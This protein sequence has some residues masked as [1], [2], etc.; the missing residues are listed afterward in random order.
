[1][2]NSNIIFL[3]F[4]CLAISF[5]SCQPEQN[6][7][8]QTIQLR[9]DTDPLVLEFRKVSYDHM[10]AMG[11]MTVDTLRQLQKKTLSCGLEYNK[12]TKAD[13]EECLKDH[14]YKDNYVTARM[15]A[16]TLNGLR[17]KI[18]DNYPEIQSLGKDKYR[19]ILGTLND[20]QLT[21]LHNTSINNLK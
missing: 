21:Q 8:L 19:L 16:K 6:I 15:L 17:K 14:P 10:V 18:N 3:F 4:L 13:L 7:D 11:S 9:L 20:E 5:G 2:K 12:T 1:M